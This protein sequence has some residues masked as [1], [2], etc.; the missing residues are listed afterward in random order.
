MI[1]SQGKTRERAKVERA[2]RGS[3]LSWSHQRRDKIMS[4]PSLLRRNSS[5]SARIDGQ[6]ATH[7]AAVI[8][9]DRANGRSNNKSEEW[10]PATT[11]PRPHED[12]EVLKGV[13]QGT[14][15]DVVSSSGDSDTDEMEVK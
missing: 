4:R 15:T 3:L 8:Q 13:E 1:L 5:I 11:R 10:F 9:E 12:Q 7:Q 2:S 6:G 14:D